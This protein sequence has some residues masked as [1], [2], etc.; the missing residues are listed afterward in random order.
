MPFHNHQRHHQA[1]PLDQ[2]YTAQKTVK[3]C[4]KTIKSLLPLI[5]TVVDSSAGHNTFCKLIQ[6][7]YPRIRTLS[8]DIDPPSEVKGQV[9]KQDFLKLNEINGAKGRVLF[10]FNP[11]FG[12]IGG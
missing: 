4:I 1:N 10:G 11:P 2:Y 8:Y 5:E 12:S 6:R 9:L 3:H 7:R